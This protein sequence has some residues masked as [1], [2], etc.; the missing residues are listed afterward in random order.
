MK[1]DVLTSHIILKTSVPM[2]LDLQAQTS[3]DGN[4]QFQWFPDEVCHYVCMLNS[5]TIRQG[6]TAFGNQRDHTMQAGPK[7]LTTETR[8]SIVDWTAFRTKTVQQ[9]SSLELALVAFN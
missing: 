3:L 2:P 6:G 8:P 4:R 5:A 7:Q 1:F 9:K